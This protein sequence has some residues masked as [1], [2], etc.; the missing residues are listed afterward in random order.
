MRQRQARAQQFTRLQL[1]LSRFRAA[2]RQKR[3]NRANDQARKGSFLS[4]LTLCTINEFLAFALIV[5]DWLE[6]R[7][8]FLIQ[9][10]VSASPGWANLLLSFISATRAFKQA[11]MFELGFQ[12]P[13]LLRSKFT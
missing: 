3:L 6:G 9:K 12:R 4:A 8:E 11:L 1:K 2:I 5:F 13:M 7:S 10:K